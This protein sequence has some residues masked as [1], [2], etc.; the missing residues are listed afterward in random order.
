MNFIQKKIIFIVSLIIATQQIN[1]GQNLTSI[2]TNNTGYSCNFVDGVK[3][4]I[5]VPSGKS[6]TYTFTSSPLSYTFGPNPTPLGGSPNGTIG[7]TSSNNKLTRTTLSG[8][9][10][11]NDTNVFQIYIAYRTS[12]GSS[13]KTILNMGSGTTLNNVTITQIGANPFSSGSISSAPKA[14]SFTINSSGATIQTIQGNITNN[15][16]ANSTNVTFYGSSIIKNADINAGASALIPLGSTFM[17]CINTIMQTPPNYYIS[18]PV[19]VTTSSNIFA[20]GSVTNTSN[21][22]VYCVFIGTINGD[23]NY[24]LA[25]GSSLAGKGSLPIITGTTRLEIYGSRNQNYTVSNLLASKTIDANSSWYVNHNNGTWTI[26]ATALQGTLLNNYYTATSTIYFNS[27]STQS[28]ISSLSGWG[29]TPIASDVINLSCRGLVN[30]GSFDITTNNSDLNIYTDSV[31]TNSSDANIYLRYY[32]PTDIGGY[33]IY[34]GQSLPLITTKNSLNISAEINGTVV[35]TATINKNTSYR[36]VY[37]G[38]AYNINAYTP[39]LSNNNSLAINSLIFYRSNNTVIDNSQTTLSPYATYAT[40]TASSFMT[41]SYLGSLIYMPITF[42]TMLNVFTGNYITNSSG[43]NVSID[44]YGD[45]NFGTNRQLTYPAIATAS[46]QTIPIS[47]GALNGIVYDSSGQRVISSTALT[48]GVS[49]RINYIDGIWSLIPTNAPSSFTLTNNF[50]SPTSTIIFYDSSA[51]VIDTI[52]SIAARSS[53]NIPTNT[54]R[55]YCTGLVNGSSCTIYATDT[56]SINIYTNYALTNNASS[57]ITATYYGSNSSSVINGSV[58][59][60][61]GQS[62]YMITGTTGISTSSIDYTQISQSSSYYIYNINSN[63]YLTDYLA[64]NYVITN[65]YDLPTSTITFYNSSSAIITTIESIAAQSSLLIPA[66]TTKIYG[67]GLINDSSCYINKNSSASFNIYTNFTLD[68]LS[69][70]TVKALYYD[71][72]STSTPIT[73]ISIPSEEDIPFITGTT[74]VAIKSASDTILIPYTMLIPNDSYFISNTTDGWHLTAYD[75]S[76]H[77]LF[78]NSATNT[79]TISFYDINLQLIASISSIP[80]ND[81]VLIP[82]GTRS[83]VATGLV[84]GSSCTIQTTGTESLNIYSNYKLT[85]NSTST[86]VVTYYGSNSQFQINGTVTIPAGQFVHLVTSTTGI[87]TP[88]IAYT[89]ISKNSSYYIYHV[90]GSWSLTNYLASIYS[91]TNNYSSPTSTMT[92]YNSS[93]AI[94]ATVSSIPAQ[95]SVLIPTG[96]TKV[97]GTGLVNNSSCN[98]NKNDTASY[99]IYTN[100]TL[101]NLSTETVSTVYYGLNSSSTVNGSV[102]IPA[103]GSV[104]MITTITGISIQTSAGVELVPYQ[105]TSNNSS[106]FINDINGTWSLTTYDASAYTL[107]NNA[108]TATSTITFYNSTNKVIGSV[109]SLGANKSVLMPEGT[110][111]IYCTGLVNESSYT[112][113]TTGNESINIY[114]NY[115]LTNHAAT[116]ILVT[117]YGS[118]SS[119]VINGSI[120]IA[121][122]QSVAIV[123]GTTGISTPSIAYTQIS[124]S[125]SYQ[126]YNINSTWYLT[127]YLASNYVITNNYDLP[128]STMTFY[129]S[130]A[131]I[132]ATVSSIPAQSSVLIPAGTTN[133]YGTGLINDS[134]CY[135]NKNSSASFNIYTNFTLDNLSTETVKALYYDTTSTSTPTGIITIPSEEDIPFITGTTAVAIKSASDTI[136]IPY[137]TLIPNDSYFISNTTDGWHL[138]AYD[139]SE[140]HLFNNSA[141]DTSTISFYD[142]N[143]QLI[144]SISSI[145]AN[146]S[147]LIP[148]GTRS[149]VA[150]GLVNGS[151][152]TIQATGTESLNIYSNYKLTNNS[153]STV[154]VTYYGSNSQFQINGTVTIPAGQ[155]VHLV[156]S[157]TGI[158]TPSIAYTPI[159]KNSSY[160][161]Y[162]VGGSWSLTNYLASIYSITNN[163]SSP[164]STM[165]FYNSSAA[166]LATVSSIPAQGSVLIPTGTTKVNGTGL[167]NNSSCN[168][169][170]NDTASYNIYTNFTLTNLSTETVSTVYYGLNSSSTVNGSVAIPASGSVPMITTITGISIQT[171]AGVE[172]VPY[173]AT[174][175]N[176]SYFINDINGTWSL[177]TYD[178]SAYTLTNNAATATST[179][180]FYNSTNKVIGSVASLGANKSVLM[181]E[182]TI[183]I[184]C[185]G[186]VNESSYTIHT[187]GN[188]SINIYT[189]YSLTNHAATPI[190][191]TYYGS[192]SSSVINGS[193]TIAA[194][195]SVAIVTGTTGISTPSIA[196]TQISQSSSYQIYN[197]NS[198]WYLTDYLASNYVITNNYDLPTSTMTFYN[199]SA[200]ILATVSSIP[201]QSSVLIPAGT[202]NVYGTGLINDSSCYINKNSSASFNIYTNFTLD[203]LSTETVKALY[204]DTTS[205]STPTGII[206]IPSE[207]DIPFITG[208]TAVAIKSAS[209]TI[210]IP[211]TTLIPNDSYF[212]SNTTDGWHLTAYDPS[213]HHLFNNSAT[214]TSTIS[215]YDI[216]LQ[217]IA[218]ISSIPANDSV[219]IP[220]GTRSILATGLVNGSSCTI[221]TTG[222]ESL[223]I[224]SNYK[225]TNNSSSAVVATY[226]GSNSQSQINGTVTIP[227]GQF[228]HIITSTTGISTPSI[229]YTPISK[230]SS[231]YIYHVGGSWSLTNYLASI[232]SITNNYSSPTSTMTFYNNSSQIIGTANSIPA[233]SSVLIPT[234]T[235]KV[236]GTG[237]V[238]NSSCDIHKN[239]AAS[240]NI[241]TNFTLTNSSTEIVNAIYYGLD[242]PLIVNGSISIPASSSVAIINSSTGISVESTVHE[243]LV[244]Y[245]A[246]INNASYFINNIDGTWSLITYGPTA[247]TLTNNSSADTSTVTFYD[248]RLTPISQT[249]LIAAGNFELIP[250]GTSQIHATGLV[251]DSSCILY[252]TGTE[253]LNIYSNYTL[254]NNSTSGITATYYGLDSQNIING[255]VTIAAGQNVPF[256]TGT[257]GVSTGSI[258]YTP[259]TENSSYFANHIGSSWFLTNYEA[260]DFAI[261]NN[262]DLP[263]STITFYDSTAQTIATI[264]SIPAQGSVLIPTGTTSVYATGLINN[265]SS[266]LQIDDSVASNIYTNFTLTNLSTDNISAVLYGLNSSSVINGLVSIPSEESIPFITSTT[267]IAI[268]SPTG[269]TVIPYTSL[270]AND[271]YFVTYN[272]T[273]GWHLTAYDPSEHHLFNNSQADTSTIS[274]YDINLQLIASVSSIAANDDV[275]IPDGT[276]SIVA[277]GL[278]NGSS[279]TIQATGTESLNIYSNYKLTNNS[280]STVVATYYGSNSSAIVNGTVSIPAGQFVHFVTSTT[281]ISTPTIAYTPISQNS[282]YYINQVNSVWSLTT[283]LASDFTITNNFGIPTKI[284]QFYNS[285]AQIIGTIPTIPAQ[286]SVLIPENTT[287]ILGAGLVN[288]SNSY[289]QIDDTISSSIYTNQTIS[290]LSTDTVKIVLYGLDSSSTVNGSV[291]TL[292]E[293]SIPFI[294]STTGI[295]VQS[296]SGIPLIAFTAI[297]DSASYFINHVDGVWSLT[298]YGPSIHTLTNNSTSAT[299]A[300]NFYN[301]S[302]E[303]L[304]SVDTV[305]AEASILLPAGTVEIHATG[306]VNDSSCILYST[307][308]E[309][310]NIYSNYTLTNNSTSGITATYYGLDSQNIINGFVTIAAGQNVPFITGTTGVSTGSIPY[311]PITENSSYFANHIGSSWFLTNY[312]ASDFAITNNYDLPTSTITFYDSTAQ[313]IATIS[314]IPAQGSVLIP[315]GTTSVYATGL[316][317]NSSSYLQ[318]DDSVASNIYTNFTLTNLSTDDIS[319][320]LYGLNSSSVINGLVSIPSEESIPFITSTTGIAIQS[321]TG[322]TVIPYTSLITNDSYFVT[323]NT[324][325][326]WHLTAYD[327]SEHHLFNNSQ[328]DTSTINFY[329][330]NLQLIA[331]ISSI[332][333]N[334]DVLI[335][336]GTRSIVATGLV[337]GSSCTIQTTGTESLNI[338]SNYKL[339]NNSTSTVVATYYGSNSSAIVNGT[340]SIPAGQFVH[341]VTSTTGISTPTIAYTPISQNSSYYINQ[342]NSVWSLTTYLASDFTITNN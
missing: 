255:F 261:T 284:I 175:N 308:T 64:S 183:K 49:Y 268:Q 61:A 248:E 304:G 40:P 211:Y 166:I 220:D 160:Y 298:T 66:G 156:T 3:S 78:N 167:V 189:N 221:Q 127:D 93:A 62:V 340:V 280:T 291:L 46:N 337:N 342:V 252:S 324:T 229:D 115:S 212:I 176:S 18:V 312:E 109:A 149:I 118:Q 84:N 111:K 44:Y 65:N 193:I 294:T 124:Q 2:F 319:A 100:F 83:I 315:T 41:F 216:N 75:P 225:L 222:T 239:D 98:I 338:Y 104:P 214:D 162:H 45:Y 204:Y 122:G 6:L 231:Y 88:S 140:H 97:N 172:L 202:T 262:Y 306:L 85:N 245:T 155:F 13:L 207:E 233:T 86:V 5:V 36:I 42:P 79:S 228:V 270:I 146:D 230:N 107:T 106:Y 287:K 179:I 56:Q 331:S 256:I 289:L 71:T 101:T 276:R 293:Q 329:D 288:D 263:T 219:L 37:T 153:T 272:T 173:Q 178:A 236:N 235:T 92:F 181:P 182:G 132:L 258:P 325:D 94:L 249:N 264:S 10:F 271:S 23:P 158:S 213:E 27:P 136:L 123:T 196:Y 15:S 313:T 8:S 141:T 332:A 164:T 246:I 282:S 273:D 58:T 241:Y 237:L 339:T 310:L 21:S 199:S 60:P 333:A 309:S 240:Y 161:I 224:Y 138:T 209:D 208:T 303:L 22:T 81:S 316:I 327:P 277:T 1:A 302:L 72:T 29:T 234:G 279:C 218:S 139:P 16:S 12:T 99:N 266:Y 31:I 163:Y 143:L 341:F 131:V 35:A 205:T 32:A 299:S 57:S 113:H 170:K 305:A 120:T 54:A 55:I 91:I 191:V 128:T 174:S 194:G 148:D 314:S 286:G 43:Q 119:S 159:S 254:T 321:P 320:V 68:N 335:P 250:L 63:W 185:T 215:F 260:S 24:A 103:S 203:N 89:P 269:T 112:I 70:E 47:T 19:S 133:V 38:S 126:I 52:S 301:E 259:I 144:A 125:S 53:V 73:T 30:G 134:S 20:A 9:R 114:T 188:E 195:Q 283:Y 275:L 117:Y 150:T 152:C 17:N 76:E 33:T 334:D 281:G 151:S 48:Q 232:Y 330:I 157:T 82:D 129:N 210:L 77:H 59:I 274:F 238:N 201:A 206:T 121:A 130:S 116:P 251:N 253:S 80:A 296:T 323:Y 26:D 11:L 311:T 102:A 242:D 192:Q 197:I 28:S 147:V 198:T 169:N 14:A 142:I 217:L 336:D 67:T 223:N 180:T 322:T 328:A 265:S 34:P 135:I 105:A 74:A 257:T 137:T 50:S 226:Y 300:I 292:S 200:V 278:V 285:S 184:Y 295:S 171:S 87:S 145:P 190:L 39:L 186:L 307:G 243:E 227:A 247:Y 4:P 165:T 267:G 317:N 7:Y 96:T 326:G 25:Y 168:I 297:E 290:N 187:T 110:I 69:T 108:A 177:T 154:V 51:K 318:I 90:G 95:G 244:S